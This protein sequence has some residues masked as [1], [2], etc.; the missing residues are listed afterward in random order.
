[1]I[2]FDKKLINI[3]VYTKEKIADIIAKIE[4]LR[5]L[6]VNTNKI[7]IFPTNPLFKYPSYTNI[8]INTNK[9]KIPKK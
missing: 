3:E 8:N 7:S 1:M 5:Q 9:I 6:F 4:N 2:N